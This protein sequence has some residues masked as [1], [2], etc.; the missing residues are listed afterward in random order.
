MSAGL[1][2]AIAL[3]GPG[4]MLALGWTLSDANQRR[5]EDDLRRELMT[6]RQLLY[7]NDLDYAPSDPVEQSLREEVEAEPS[8]SWAVAELDAVS[9]ARLSAAEIDL[10]RL[11]RKADREAER[12]WVVEPDLARANTEY[13]RTVGDGLAGMPPRVPTAGEKNLLRL[14]AEVERE[15]RSGA[16]VDE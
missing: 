3:L 15:Q 2:I 1:S 6:A 10:R 14:I 7:E 9:Q 12:R 16:V 11:H 13:A 4:V 8:L 5:K